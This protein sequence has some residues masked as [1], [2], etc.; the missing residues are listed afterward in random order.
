MNLNNTYTNF[1]LRVY[2]LVG[3]NKITIIIIALRT[4]L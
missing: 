4:Q 2:K 3:E 1:I